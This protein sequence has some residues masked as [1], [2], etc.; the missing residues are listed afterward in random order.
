MTTS[1]A[2]VIPVLPIHDELEG[3]EGVLGAV[4]ATALCEADVTDLVGSLQ[5]AGASVHTIA[6]ALNRAG[7]YSPSGQRW[8]VKSVRRRIAG[9]AKPRPAVTAPVVTRRNRGSVP[10]HDAHA[11]ADRP[12]LVQHVSVYFAEAL[13]RGASCVVIT[14][15]ADRYSIRRAL[16]ALGLAGSLRSPRYVE[17]DSELLLNE[18]MRDGHPDPVL[19]EAVVLPLLDVAG[20]PVHAYGD[21]VDRLWN[22]GNVTGALHIEDLLNGLQRRVPFHRLCGYSAVGLSQGS[23]VDLDRLRCGHT[24]VSGLQGRD[25]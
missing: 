10:R 7:T 15:S 24:Q 6:A 4:P 20:S 8:T 25:S 16:T 12:D 21:M 23:S 9:R 11:Y 1:A 3:T 5:L 22:A 14:D 17:V 19:F 13:F 18:F 2:R